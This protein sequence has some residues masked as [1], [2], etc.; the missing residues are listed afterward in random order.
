MYLEAYRKPFIPPSSASTPLYVKSVYYFGE[1]HPAEAK[2]S[3]VVAVDD[4][5]LSSPSAIHT[6]KLLAGPRWTP[7][8]PKDAGVMEEEAWGNGYIKISSD[9]FASGEMNLKWVS[10]A[11][12]RL[13]ESANVRPRVPLFY[14]LRKLMVVCRMRKR[15]LQTFPSICAMSMRRC[16]KARRATILGIGRSSALALRTFRRSGSRRNLLPP[17]L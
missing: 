6:I 11:L 1:P 4:L 7:N 17:L 2:R 3:L 10:D 9:A 14:R 13:V 16:G 12:D 15:A 5:P 8:P